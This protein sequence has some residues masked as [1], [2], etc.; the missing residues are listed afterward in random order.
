MS[1]VNAYIDSLI[2]PRAEKISSVVGY[3]R[4]KYPQAIESLDYAP[5]T[6]FPTFKIGEVYVTIASMKS[7][8]S[9]HFGA[10]NATSIVAKASPKIKERV[11][12]VNIP[13]SID[14]PLEEIKNAIDFCFGSAK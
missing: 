4:L 12:C 14:F 5:K 11:G 8:I 10:Y 7:H 1:T 3:I 9:I 13:D 2:T 6:K